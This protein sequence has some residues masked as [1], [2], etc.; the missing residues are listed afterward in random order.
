MSIL[1]T[2]VS[3]TKN[4]TNNYYTISTSIIYATVL[5]YWIVALERFEGSC[6][7][8]WY[9]ISDPLQGL[10]VGY[11][12]H[13]RHTGDCVQEGNEA[14]LVVG[15]CKPGSMVE[16]SHGGPVDRENNVYPAK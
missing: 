12:P 5:T 2:T 9:W 8:D 6:L 4:E 10:P 3:L 1:K 11:Q 15:C 14:L 7:R 13:I 16:K